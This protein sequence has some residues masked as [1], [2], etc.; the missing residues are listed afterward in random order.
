MSDSKVTVT[1]REGYTGHHHMGREVQPGEQIEVW[2]DQAAFLERVGAIEPL[3]RTS[4]RKKKESDEQSEPPATEP[5]EEA[6]DGT[7]TEG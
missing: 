2:L 1:I 7:T 6:P 4:G 5:E 3:K